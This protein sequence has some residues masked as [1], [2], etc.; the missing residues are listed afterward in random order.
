MNAGT[1]DHA[2]ASYL[3]FRSWVSP[4]ARRAFVDAPRRRWAWQGRL[5]Y[6]LYCGVRSAA[7]TAILVINANPVADIPGDL[8]TDL[9]NLCS[10]TSMRPQNPSCAAV[11]VGA[12]PGHDRAIRE[13]RAFPA[14]TVVLLRVSRDRSAHPRRA[15]ALSASELRRGR[16]QHRRLGPEHSAGAQAGVA[17]V[18]I[19]LAVIDRRR[20]RPAKKV[21]DHPTK[22]PRKNVLM[23]DSDAPRASE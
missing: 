10:R 22:R 19:G 13:S 14:S 2:A 4:D 12:T 6:R 21:G 11:P 9:D 5:R 8:R 23:N 1:H 17:C 18:M 16:R 3:T 20:R 15:G 7:R